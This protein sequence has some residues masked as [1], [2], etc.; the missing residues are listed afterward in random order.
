LGLVLFLG[1]EYFLHSLARGVKNRTANQLL[2]PNLGSITMKKH[3]L[4]ATLA[5]SSLGAMAADQTVN[6]TGSSVNFGSTAPLLLGGDDVISFT[7][8]AAGSYDLTLSLTSQF[9]AL[10]SVTLNG[11][12]VP[13]LGSFFGGVLKLYGVEATD[14]SPF[15]LT[16]TGS[17]GVPAAAGYAGTLSAELNPVTIPVPEPETYAMLLAGLAAMGFMRRR[18]TDA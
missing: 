12:A 3:L 6:F 14:D 9:I 16:L 2:Q 5:L 7:G 18:R 17:V 1:V 13:E 15:T 8:L 11:I 4:A 10:T